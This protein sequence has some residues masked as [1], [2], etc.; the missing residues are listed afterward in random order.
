MIDLFSNEKQANLYTWVN[1]HNRFLRSQYNDLLHQVL[2][3]DK[4]FITSGDTLQTPNKLDPP[5]YYN[6][7]FC[8]TLVNN[9][10]DYG[11]ILTRLAGDAKTADAKAD[12]KTAP[13]AA[14]PILINTGGVVKV[15]M[16]D[17]N[18]DDQK[19]PQ[20]M[21]RREVTTVGGLDTSINLYN[22]LNFGTVLWLYYYER[23]G[24][25]EILNALMKDYNYTGRLPISSKSENT[26]TDNSLRYSELME[27][28]SALYRM[29][30]GSFT[31]DRKALYQ[32]VLG[33]TWTADDDNGGKNVASETNGA[34]MR[35]FDKVTGLMIDFYRDKQL[36][37]AIRDTN[38]SN[39]R[40]LVATQTS[41]RDTILVLQKNMEVFEY[42]RNRATTFLGVATVFATVCLL[43]MLKDEIG[44]PRQYN[45]PHEFIPAAY[46]I[47][48][49][50]RSVT[51]TETNR[52][53]IFDNCASYGYRLLT[54]IELIN[55]NELKTIAINSTLDAWLNDVEGVVEGYNNAR[56]S[57][58][59][60]VMA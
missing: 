54:D 55:T 59:E 29:G 6:P 51:S 4:N 39:I 47:L 34:F 19:L 12:K 53:T 23:M 17:Y 49:K 24:I 58:A 42:G 27:S 26:T 25:F 28:I 18:Y 37:Q 46:D 33:V 16:E 48:I 52:F 32:R 2:Q 9:N 13:A 36:A 3:K 11:S 1:I 15:C 56:K 41:I 8:L 38:T 30:I 44:V 20:F 43:R 57:V 45:D 60:P 14:E 5:N 40:S 10:C 31:A 35:N 50:G 22:Q 7:N 21:Y